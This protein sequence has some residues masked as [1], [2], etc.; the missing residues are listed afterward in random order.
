MPGEHYPLRVCADACD[1]PGA[2]RAR[3][4]GGGLQ[5]RVGRRDFEW[6]T[7]LRASRDT[8]AA[9]DLPRPVGGGRERDPRVSC[10]AGRRVRRPGRAGRL[11]VH[12]DGFGAGGAGDRRL[13]PALPGRAV[14]VARRRAPGLG[15]ACGSRRRALGVHLAEAAGNAVDEA[16]AS[17]RP[18]AAAAGGRRHAGRV[19]RRLGDAGRQAAT[20][21]STLQPPWQV[22]VDAKV[23]RPTPDGLAIIQADP[24]AYADVAVIQLGTNDGG[25]PDVYEQHVA[26][27]A[28][29]LG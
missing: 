6:G 17:R 13:G 22:S 10:R 3:P 12:R 21:S 7:R 2:H 8:G 5:R 1:R 23:S 11:P 20:S 26:E 19:H 14:C 27:I 28:D 9:A 29:A 15:R 4:P 18:L 25:I 24:S 16:R